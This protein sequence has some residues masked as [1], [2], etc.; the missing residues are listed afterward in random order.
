MKRYTRAEV[1]E[2]AA[3]ALD[4][5]ITETLERGV[6]C[7]TEGVGDH[8]GPELARLLDRA[9]TIDALERSPSYR[10]DMGAFRAA[11]ERAAE[12]APFEMPPGTVKKGG[13]D[14]E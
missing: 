3:E 2:L 7:M 9:E 8:F 10:V 4:L 12:G 6:E 13:T 14:A 5:A 1:E 11:C